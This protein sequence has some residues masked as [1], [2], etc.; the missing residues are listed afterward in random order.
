[1]KVIVR[2]QEN[3]VFTQ[4]KEFIGPVNVSLDQ[5]RKYAIVEVF[6]ESM[7]IALKI[8]HRDNDNI[9]GDYVDCYRY[10]ESDVSSAHFSVNWEYIQCGFCELV[11][12]YID[13]SGE[14]GSVSINS[15]KHFFFDLVRFKN[16]YSKV[17]A[18]E[19]LRDWPL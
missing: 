9:I 18:D 10:S 2:K 11:T 3:G 4:E 17:T 6:D 8:D 1:M 13:C 16:V 14:S 15:I 7:F 5:E 12:T 19:V